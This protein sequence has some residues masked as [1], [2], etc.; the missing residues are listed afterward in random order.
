MKQRDF[1]FWVT[2]SM[3]S[4]TL[5]L[6]LPIITDADTAKLERI[7]L[8]TPLLYTQYFFAWPPFEAIHFTFCIFGHPQIPPRNQLPFTT[9][10]LEDDLPGPS[11]IGQVKLPELVQEVKQFWGWEDIRCYHLCHIKA[12]I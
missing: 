4:P 1:T 10:S 2:F 3:L 7:L 6:Q 9:I 5:L 8:S 11:L 12:F